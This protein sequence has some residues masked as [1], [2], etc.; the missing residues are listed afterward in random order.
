MIQQN[1]GLT[2]GIDCRMYGLKHAGIGRYIKNIVDRV[3]THPHHRFVLFG[4]RSLEKLTQPYPRVQVIPT[5][6]RHYSLQEQLLLPR[7]FHSVHLDVLHVPHF[8]IPLLYRQPLI[9]TIH[10]LLWHQV[11]GPEVTTLSPLIYTLKYQ[12]YRFIVTK[13][14]SRSQAIIV[15]SFYVKHQIL[16][17]YPQ[18]LP[19]KINV[20]Y[21]ASDVS[22]THTAKPLPTQS[23][24][25]VYIGSAY[26]HKNLP[27]LIR[28]V[29]N[30]HDTHDQPLN[31]FIIS[32]RDIFLDQAKQLITQL[33][34]AKYIRF[35]GF[36]PDSEVA[37]YVKHALALVHPSTS[38]GFGLTGL[39]AM[40]A[41]TPVI[42][43][44]DASLP[45][46]YG[47]AALYIDSKDPESI[48]RA[49]YD[50]IK[51]P[52]LRRQLIHQGRIQ[53][54]K[55]NWDQASKQTLKLY[56]SVLATPS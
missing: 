33:D 6:I 35:L 34:A 16:K 30:F 49:I 50:L 15:P 13:A 32:A 36:L 12:A 8:N 2:I 41:G 11:Q 44:K 24:Y 45:E 14:V 43:S 56:E 29:K 40:S 48:S 21:E 52:P 37:S 53:A 27:T 23:P 9:T 1:S 5:T 17:Y 22:F 42:S 4:S 31:C 51:D 7:L 47:D 10:D 28:A 54:Q 19:S 25:V 20:I 38:E 55:Y 46:I 3:I 39:E 18:T 26:P